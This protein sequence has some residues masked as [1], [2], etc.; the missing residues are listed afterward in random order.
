MLPV[1]TLKYLAGSC[2]LLIMAGCTTLN[3]TV[4]GYLGL[5]TDLELKLKVDS[6]IN[7]DDNKKPSPLFIRM[8]SLKS[9]KMFNKADFIDLY[10]IDKEVL[11]ADLLNKQVLK[12]LKPGEDQVETFV[13]DKKTRY[14]ALFAEFLQYKNAEYRVIIPVVPNNVVATSATILVS[15]NRIKLLSNSGARN[16]DDENLEEAEGKAK[17]AKA[18]ADKAGEAADKAQSG[19]EKL[20]KLF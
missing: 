4:G 18:K 5:D 19:A 3:S 10:E 20:E 15:G 11:G 1:K 12:R 14:V 13:L 16:E 2:L 17:N 6:D 8:Y 9:T 7:P